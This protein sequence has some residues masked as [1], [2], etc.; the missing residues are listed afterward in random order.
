MEKT[1]DW[2][3]LERR[4]NHY[5]HLFIKNRSFHLFNLEQLQARYEQ[6]ERTEELANDIEDMIG[7]G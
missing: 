3:E 1:I 7:N 6:G 5:R 2:S 4:M